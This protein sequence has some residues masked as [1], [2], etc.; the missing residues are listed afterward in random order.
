MTEKER[1]LS[2]MLYKAACPDLW[3]DHK[4]AL[5]LTRLYNASTEEEQEY[6]KELLKELLG[7]CGEKVYIEPDFRCDYGSNIYIGENFFAN[8]GCV[9]LDVCRVDIGN[10]VMLAPGTGLFTAAHPI[11]PDVRISGLEYGRPIKI[12]DNVWLGAGTKVNPGVTVGKNSVVGSGSVVT[13][14]VPENVVA[15]GN[16]CRV[17]REI[18]REDKRRWNELAEEYRNR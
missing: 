10:N 4:R 5:R 13:K 9:I 2:G 7:S 15:A 14:D 6:R 8:Y 3:N 18:T 16:P 12:C 11:D 17:I 1:M